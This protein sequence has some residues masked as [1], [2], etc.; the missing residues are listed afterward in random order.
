VIF[1]HEGSGQESRDVEEVE[2]EVGEHLRQSGWGDR[3]A[4]VVIAPEL[5]AWVW[6]DSPQVDQVLGWRRRKIGLRDWLHGE[7]LWPAEQPK[8]PD[9]KLAMERT[10]YHLRRPRSSAIY[11]EL[12]KKVSLQ[13]CRDRSFCRLVRIL[14]SWFPPAEGDE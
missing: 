3:A 13:R 9:P 6:S 5:E 1:D 7:G 12:A 11:G 14:R 4:A 2:K 10:L 8:P